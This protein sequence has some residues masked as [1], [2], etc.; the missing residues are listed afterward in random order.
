MASLLIVLPSLDIGSLG[1]SIGSHDSIAQ[2]SGSLQTEERETC[3]EIFKL[4]FNLL[5]RYTLVGY[6]L[7]VF[8]CQHTRKCFIIRFNIFVNPCGVEPRQ[9][10]HKNTILSGE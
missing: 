1:I 5:F 4:F 10:H 2:C 3:L 9:S 6:L 8:F 7:K